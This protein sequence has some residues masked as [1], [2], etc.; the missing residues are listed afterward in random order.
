MTCEY[1]VNLEF[2]EIHWRS[3]DIN[4]VQIVES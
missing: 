1:I 4:K 3:N 2:G